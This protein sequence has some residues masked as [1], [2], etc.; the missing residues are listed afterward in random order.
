MLYKLFRR[1][2]LS[3][4]LLVSASAFATERGIMLR[5]SVI[6]VAPNTSS[7]KISNISRGREV[8]VMERTPGWM[9]VVG[10]VEVSPDP[11]N[12][13]DRNVTG[14]ILDKGI[15][16]TT[17]PDGDKIL[18][19]E[20]FDCE[21]EA[22]HRNGRRGAAQDALRLYAR[23]ASTLPVPPWLVNRSTVQPTFAGRRTLKTR[24]PK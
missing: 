24:L 1:S 18:F 4:L 10:T 6:Y 12:E 16:T 3:I 22:S 5:E 17:T 14:W 11:D 13:A 20:A 8:A 21:M 2:V 9:N 15:I 7:A 23:I 19:G